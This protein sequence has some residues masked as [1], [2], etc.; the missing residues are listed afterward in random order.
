MSEARE[1]SPEPSDGEHFPE[2]KLD[3]L[4]P[5]KFD[6]DW[7]GMFNEGFGQG[8]HWTVIETSFCLVQTSGH[9]DFRRGRKAYKALDLELATGSYDTPVFGL[10]RGVKLIHT[11]HMV[12]LLKDG[13]YERETGIEPMPFIV[14]SDVDI[15]TYPAEATQYPNQQV[16][17]PLGGLDKLELTLD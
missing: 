17:V 6:S 7:A 10:I 4:L 5:E 11:P 9:S 3:I 13:V 2:S 12:Q 15:P 14:L 1:V 16:L 8:S